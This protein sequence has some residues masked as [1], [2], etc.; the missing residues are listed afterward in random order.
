MRQLAPPRGEGLWE[1]LRWMYRRPVVYEVAAPYRATVTVMGRRVT[2]LLPRGFRTDLA[3][4]PRPAWLFGF[5]PDAPALLVPALWHDWY[6]RHGY[7]LRSDGAR[8]AAGRGRHFADREFASQ[9]RRMTGLWFPALVVWAALR[10]FG[11]FAWRNNEP[12]RAAGGRRA[13][14]GEYDNIR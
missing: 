7:Y 12:F 13:L 5:R 8:W 10:V 14:R 3:S 6:Y 11:G 9:V 4:T 1:R 2:L